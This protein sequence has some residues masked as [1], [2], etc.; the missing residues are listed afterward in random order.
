MNAPAEASIF[1]SAEN[2]VHY[3]SGETDVKMTVMRK[4]EIVGV[5]VKIRSHCVKFRLVVFSRS[6]TI[7]T[8]VLGVRKRDVSLGTGA[9]SREKVIIVQGL[10]AESIYSALKARITK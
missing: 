2:S 8:Q 5:K 6:K 7:M 4:L 9:R 3:C 1:N 10:S